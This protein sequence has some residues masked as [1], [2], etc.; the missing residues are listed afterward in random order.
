M[1]FPQRA[2]DQPTSPS[3]VAVA[4]R[5]PSNPHARRRHPSDG[6]SYRFWRQIWR[7][8]PLAVLIPWL[9]FVAAQPSPRHYV[10]MEYVP[11]V[12]KVL[13][14]GGYDSGFDLS[15]AADAMWWWD[16]S[17]GSW[18]EGNLEGG[19]SPR[20]GPA[21][22]VHAP[23]GMVLVYGGASGPR[24]N[25]VR[26]LPETWLYDPVADAWETLE[27][28]MTER[29]LRGVGEAL[30]Y[31]AGADVFVLFGG[32]SLGTGALYA[33]TWH[34]DLE[35]KTWSK[36]ETVNAPDGRNYVG[37]DYHPGVDRIVMYGSPDYVN[38]FHAYI[39]DPASATW[40]EASAGPEGKDPDH[41]SRLVFD[42]DSGKLVRFGGTGGH[43]RQVWTY[44]P[45]TDAWS[46]LVAEGTGPSRLSRH[47]MTSVPGVGIVVFGGTTGI[48]P[49]V[50]AN[51]TSELW[52]LDVVAGRWEQR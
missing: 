39:Y 14:F 12:G 38:D 29:P 50:T 6:R 21:I 9:G 10:D 36:Q 46:E 2:P 44:D 5:P 15:G 47:A 35:S 48:S 16:P 43:A 31:H 52:V 30:A 32:M 7:V 4:G 8:G 3:T 24:A 28:A 11:Q 34:F 20:G 49:T 40:T 17:D 27:F 23:T 51:L 41:Y 45:V 18:T 22:A 33:D 42:H 13:V 25:S 1:S 19:P 37:F 26:E